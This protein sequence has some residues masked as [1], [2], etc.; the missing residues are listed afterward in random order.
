M[1]KINNYIEEYISN[2]LLQYK[3]QILNIPQINEQIFNNGNKSRELLEKDTKFVELI[4]FIQKKIFKDLKI[5]Y[6]NSNDDKMK[7]AH[8]SYYANRIT[9]SPQSYNF[10]VKF[11]Y[12]FIIE[13]SGN[14]GSNGINNSGIGF[15]I[16]KY[17]QNKDTSNFSIN[18]YYDG[19][20]GN[21]IYMNVDDIQITNPDENTIKSKIKNLLSSSVKYI[22]PSIYLD[23]LSIKTNLEIESFFKKIEQFKFD[24]INLKFN[25]LNKDYQE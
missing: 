1:N 6:P 15:K 16:I 19:Y 21:K 12:D 24:E 11:N 5:Y 17:N 23:Y 14:V 13:I 10:E 8:L 20:N 25:N 18:Y 7:T 4:D 22:H 2:E 3:N 9:N